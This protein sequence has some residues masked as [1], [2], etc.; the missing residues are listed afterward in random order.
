MHPI[1]KFFKDIAEATWFQNFITW[2]IIAAGVVV[3]AQT[4]PDFVARY[5]TILDVLDSCIL[6]I[7]VAEV[8]IKM[9]A[10]GKRPWRYFLDGWNVFD[11]IIVAACFLPIGAQYAMVLRL[12]RLLRVLKLVRA[13]PK[14][15]ILVG[16]LLK[17]IP[18]IGYISILL[19]MLFYLY[20]VTGTFLFSENDPIHFRNLQ[21]SMLSLFRA[22]TLED[23]TDLMYI[24]MAGC[25]DYGY[26]GIEHLCTSS[27]AR[28]IIGASFFVSFILIGT[29]IIL[30]LFIGVIMNG[31]DEARAEADA[32][33]EQERQSLIPEGEAPTLTDD[34]KELEGKMAELQQQ[35][36]RMTTKAA[37]LKPAE[38]KSSRSRLPKG[39]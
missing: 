1:R 35:I 5:G 33:I 23:W 34:L 8:V 25:A 12:A 9:A 36:A 7:F 3:G 37:E 20:A 30:N 28:P 2:V 4:Y 18:S 11:F 19:F 26:G 32:E 21:T 17:S 39:P 29:M 13:L 14:L 15:Q 31:M 24:Q 27:T 38:A 6:W 16:A 22:V 10:E